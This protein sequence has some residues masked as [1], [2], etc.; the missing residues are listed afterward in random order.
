MCRFSILF[1]SAVKFGP[2]NPLPPKTLTKQQFDIWYI[3]IQMWL[4]E[5]DVLLNFLPDGLYPQWQSKEQNPHRIAAVA[6]ANPDILQNAT[7]QQMDTL[8]TKRKRETQIF[9][10]QVAKCVCEN[11]Y[12]LII[13]HTTSLEW[14]FD[15]I[16]RDYDNKK[17]QE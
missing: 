10:S 13:R 3:E 2:P 5:D 1:S 8:R 15:V 12:I 9:P 17:S 11:H 16:K 7:Q 14:I 6:T 4:G